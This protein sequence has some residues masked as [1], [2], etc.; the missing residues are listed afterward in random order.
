MVGAALVPAPLLSAGVS[1]LAGRYADR[2]G[3]RWILAVSSAVCGLFFLSYIVVLDDT[4]AVWTGF[5]PI[6]IVIGLGIGASIA[7]W[8]SAGLADV[9]PGQFGT[10]NATVRTTQQV[11]YAL[12]I[13]VIVA[14]LANVSVDANLSSF[15]WAWAFVGGCYLVSGIVV[16]LAFP[17]G[18]S[19][20]RA[21]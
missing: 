17:S 10:A 11:G 9:S 21:A 3:H 19:E 8:A 2:V 6:S 1:P 4:P 12:G 7:T 16:A 14:I 5:V 13:S 20:A 18:S 15:R